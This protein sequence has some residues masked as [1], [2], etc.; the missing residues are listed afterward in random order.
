MSDNSI[1]IVPKISSYPNNEAKAREVLAWLIAQ[2][3]VEARCSDCTLGEAGYAVSEGAKKVTT[4][5]QLLPLDLGVNGMEI[6]TQRRVFDAGANGLNECICPNCKKNIATEEW[7]FFNELY[8]NKSNCITCPLCHTSAE[9]HAFN[10]SPQWGFSDLGF[11]FWNWPPFTEIFIE[12]FKI[13][14]NCDV[15]VVF[16][17]I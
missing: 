17:H 7:D 15:S 6:I 14:L 12:E 10:F 3:I 4:N 5:P 8:E 9:I 13:K 1:A 16:Q 11:K 2:D